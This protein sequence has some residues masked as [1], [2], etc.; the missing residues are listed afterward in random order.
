MTTLLH[1]GDFLIK[2]D[3]DR[4]FMRKFQVSDEFAEAP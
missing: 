2:D 4:M 1:R 3:I